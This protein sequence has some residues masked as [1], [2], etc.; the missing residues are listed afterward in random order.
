VRV[1]RLAPQE[2][3][4]EIAR[5]LGGREPSSVATEHARELLGRAGRQAPDAAAKKTAAGAKTPAVAKN[6]RGGKP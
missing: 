6:A 4:E 1:H 3:L 2:R 5:M